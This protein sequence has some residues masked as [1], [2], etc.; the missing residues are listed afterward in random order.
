MD[1]GYHE[2]SEQKQ[3]DA[4]RTGM[5]NSMGYKVIRFTNSQIISSYD[6][7][8]VLRIIDKY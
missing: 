2:T 1:G 8:W 5:L 4:W 3:K 7:N 6:L